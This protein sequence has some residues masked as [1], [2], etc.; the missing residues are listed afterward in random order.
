MLLT[1]A[2]GLLS[3][4]LLRHLLKLFKGSAKHP[5]IYINTITLS[6]KQNIQVDFRQAFIHCCELHE[7]PGK[8]LV[9]CR[10]CWWQRHDIPL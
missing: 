5:S 2:L 3:M 7:V 8:L 4:A 6:L 9:L 1:V 10:L